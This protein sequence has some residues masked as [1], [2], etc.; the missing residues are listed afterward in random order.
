M[1]KTEFK[2][3]K[4]IMISKKINTGNYENIDV[5][6]SYEIRGDDSVEMNNA[7]AAFK[8]KAMNDITLIEREIKQKGGM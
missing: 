7:I 5:G 6:F 2:Y 1:E 8:K 3:K 4:G